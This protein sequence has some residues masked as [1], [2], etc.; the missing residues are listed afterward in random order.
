MKWLHFRGRPFPLAGLTLFPG[1]DDGRGS[2]AQLSGGV[3]IFCGGPAPGTGGPRHL[4][5][6]LAFWSLLTSG[7]TWNSERT[8]PIIK[9]VSLEHH[10]FRIHLST[11]KKST[12]KNYN[13]KLN[14][15]SIYWPII[16]KLM[17]LCYRQ[18]R[19]AGIG[20]TGQTAVWPGFLNS[21]SRG[22]LVIICK[23]LTINYRSGLAKISSGVPVL[24]LESGVLRVTDQPI[25]QISSLSKV[26]NYW[27]N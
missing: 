23:D 12:F 6:V 3:K 18:F 15:R 11:V 10:D 8:T 14:L 25:F 7:W 26:H 22:Y 2:S 27:I 13:Q 24:T 20:Q 19:D 5:G 1:L 21:Q 17:N 9:H 16:I 4:P